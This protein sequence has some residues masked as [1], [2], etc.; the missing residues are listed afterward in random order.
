MEGLVD[1]IQSYNRSNPFRLHIWTATPRPS[2]QS[3]PSQVTVRFTI[4][5]VVTVFLTV[6]RTPDSI[7]V[8]EGATAFG[9]REKVR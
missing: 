7:V 4:H 5:D 3:L 1:Y 6:G 9:P 8:V 2:G